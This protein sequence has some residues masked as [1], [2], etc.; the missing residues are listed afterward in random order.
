MKFGALAVFVTAVIFG[1][2]ASPSIAHAA[3]AID[4]ASRANVIVEGLNDRDGTGYSVA[5]AGDVNGDGRSDIVVGAPRHDASRGH[6][7]AAW[8]LYGRPRETQIDLRTGVGE[9]GFPITGPQNM[10]RFG[11][12]VAGAGDVNGDGLD[13]VIV[14]APLA[15]PGG[16]AKGEAWVVFGQTENQPVSTFGES[17]VDPRF[18]QAFRIRGSSAFA[19]TGDSVAGAGDVNGDGLDDVVVGAPGMSDQEPVR[20]TNGAAYVVY[21]KTDREDVDLDTPTFATQ[22]FRIDG[23]LD[24]DTA[25]TSVAPA[26]DVDADGFD[27]VLVGAP[28]AGSA[29]VVF[30]KRTPERVDLVAAEVDLGL[31]QGIPAVRLASAE[32]GDGAGASV[33]SAGDVNDDG[34]VDVIVGA[35]HSAGAGRPA[36][37]AAYVVLGTGARE[38]ATLGSLGARGYRIVGE[39]AGDR[40]GWAVAGG[41]DLGGSASPDVAIG[42]PFA[43]H[44]GRT[45]SGSAY[46]VTGAAG[47]TVDLATGSYA[48]RVDGESPLWEGE[49]ARNTGW[50]L[51]LSPDV[52]LDGVPDVI[53]GARNGAR[54]YAV[55][56]DVTPPEVTLRS[57]AD[58]SEHHVGD[59]LV[60]DYAC[61][62]SG[63][64]LLA[65]AGAVPSGGPIDTGTLGAKTFAVEARDRAG[66]V[67]R[68]TH[69][70]R[71][72]N[73]APDC[74]ALVPSPSRLLRPEGDFR[75]VVIDG[76]LDPDGDAVQLH[77]RTVTQD[78]PLGATTPDARRVEEAGAVELRAE[79][80][81]NG[82]GRVYRIGVELTDQ[83]GAGCA[84]TVRV[85]VPHD[86]RRRSAADSGRVV[87][88]FGG[89]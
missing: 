15:G 10:S 86:E 11:D 14:G 59:R 45:Y 75:R 64:G 16:W 73:T 36:S 81:G 67:A 82:D 66:N 48:F 58:G 74:A 55:S 8:V 68:V 7:G 28:G 87:D 42:A 88:S 24:G 13:D 5:A 41:V 6:I 32:T 3:S 51:A 44:N 39:K 77:I 4:L 21:G 83:W 38:G 29:Y 37:G 43:D 25:G 65:C 69:G 26:G 40:A 76:A 71:V 34:N 20:V 22:G 27:D 46:V 85:E 57:P 12:A 2:V 89:G 62:D 63:A 60:A 78:E 79:R 52:D 49:P 19:L 35:P 9:A 50:A 56:S 84:T 61:E 54:A 33:A 72:V 70:Y 17:T 23:A 1:V 53:L 80:D 47:S 18:K 30:G 31:R